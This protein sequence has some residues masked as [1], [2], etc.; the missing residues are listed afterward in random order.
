MVHHL[1]A[2][3]K[4]FNLL[5]M[6]KPCFALNFVKIKTHPPTNPLIPRVSERCKS[7]NL[8]K[9]RKIF[10]R[11]SF[12]DSARKIERILNI[13]LSATRPESL[14]EFTRK[15]FRRFVK[16]LSPICLVKSFK[17]FT[18]TLNGF[19]LKN[20]SVFRS[21]YLKDLSVKI[22]HRFKLYRQRICLRKSFGDSGKLFEGFSPGNLSVYSGTIGFMPSQNPWY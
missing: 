8:S 1:T 22:F 17:L 16:N 6:G 7:V 4:K 9:P 21:N 3:N 2:T 13:N 15:I 12:K 18:P 11:E 5:S 10:R 14:K 20:L 19:I